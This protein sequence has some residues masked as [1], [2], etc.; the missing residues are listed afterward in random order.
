M[1]TKNPN[2]SESIASADFER[3]RLMSLINSM[4]DAVIAVNDNAN[5]V[6]YN[7]AALNIFDTNKSLVGTALHDILKITDKNNQPI[8]LREYILSCKTQQTNR[9]FRF[10]YPD[11]TVI[12]IFLSVAPV[13]LGWGS[14]GRQGYVLLIRDITRE[15]SLEEERDEFISVISH[16]LRTPIAISEGETSNALLIAKKHGANIQVLDAIEQAHEQILFLSD[17]VNDLS[18]LSRAERGKLEVE[19]EKI[20]THDLLQELKASYQQQTDGKGLKLFVEHDPKI[21]M[22]NSSKLYVREILQNFITNAIKYTEAGSVSI[23]AHQTDNGVRFEVSDTGIGISQ[24]DQQRVFDKF[25][26][27]EDYRTRA[28]NGSGLGLYVTIKLARLIHADIDI[29]S[30]LDHGSTFIIQIPNLK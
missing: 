10:T 19:V 29:K 27:S 18:T 30:Q 22:L 7:A 11:D 9:D 25:F 8:D 4:G 28:S 16:E 6:L 3:Q 14:K 21:T 5:I 23:A 24:P 13:K 17:M 15:K 26:R 2:H 12:N 1:D 20:N